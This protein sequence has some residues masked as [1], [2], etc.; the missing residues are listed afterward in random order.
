MPAGEL[1]GQM[2]GIR[3]R[4]QGREQKTMRIVR[5][6]DRLVS[7]A[8]VI[9]VLTLCL[10]ISSVMK[11]Q[12][13][14][15]RFPKLGKCF[16]LIAPL[17]NT[18]PLGGNLV[19]TGVIS[20]PPNASQFMAS[21]CQKTCSGTHGLRPLFEHAMNAIDAT[22]ARW[23][24][25]NRCTVCPLNRVREGTA[26]RIKQLCAS[27]EVSQRLREIGFGE[28]QIIRLLASSTNVICLVCNARL[29]LSA[30]LA[31]TILVE[32]LKQVQTS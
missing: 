12:V 3:E 32:P 17:A 13:D 10:F 1:A 15:G 9:F 14:V 29:A 18:A 16:P 23:G 27:R 26:V 24:G 7:L 2:S 28:E 25:E 11:P 30:H 20:R 22:F 31:E 4:D 8:L 5:P 19:A 21:N 6:A